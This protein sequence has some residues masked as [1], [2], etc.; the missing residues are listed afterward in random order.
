MRLVSTTP[1]KYFCALLILTLGSVLQAAENWPLKRDIDLSSGFGDYRPDRFHTGVDIRTGG[2]EG[3]PILSPVAGYVYRVKMSYTG[4]GKG[5]YVMGDDGYLYVYGHL[6]L[7]AP[8]IDKPVKTAQLNSKRYYQDLYFPRDSIRIVEG[9]YLGK[10]GKT[11]ANAPHLHFE[12]RSGE[13]YPVNPLTHGFLLSDKV[14]PTFTRI[15]FKL[16]D[17]HSLLENGMRESFFRARKVGDGR[18]KIDSLLYFHRPFGIIAGCFDQMRPGGMKQGIYK[19]SVYVDDNLRYQVIFDSL[20]FDMQSSVNLEYKYDSVVVNDDKWLRVLY[21]KPGNDFDISGSA[22]QSGGII[23]LDWKDKPGRHLGTV[24]AEDCFGN[25][26]ELQFE[27]LWG[28]SE[29]IFT[30]D[31]TVAETP[32]ITKFYFSPVDGY[33]RLGLDSVTV[34]LNR[35]NLWGVSDEVT[36]ELQPDGHLVSVADAYGTKSA[37]LRLGVYVGKKLIPDNLF[38]GLQKFGKE[39]ASVQHEILDDGLLLVLNVK[40]KQGAQAR[41]A[42]FDGDSLLGVVFPRYYTMLQYR[43]FIPPLKK[44]GHITKIG[45]AVTRDTSVALKY[46][47]TLNIYEVGR[48]DDQ[49]INLGDSTTIRFRKD[50]FFAPRFVELKHWTVLGR[51]KYGLNSGYFEITPAAFACKQDFEVD[52][53]LQKHPILSPKTGICWLDEKEN[54]WVW[55]DNTIDSN[56][57][58]VAA[59]AEGGGIFSAH[60][61]IVPPEIRDLNIVNGRTYTNP[62]MT[63]SFALKDTLSGFFDDRNITIKLDSKW[64]IPEFDPVTGICKTWPNEPLSNGS[65]HLGIIVTDRAGNLTEQYLNF[66]MRAKK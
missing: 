11:G 45:Y 29:N 65:H 51:S 2:V 32:K 22:D 60:F 62:T 27:F 8:K 7:F 61:D 57:Y 17:D 35:G 24:V 39:I 28:P 44:Y 23:G 50:G 1:L 16:T 56:S 58:S 41:L 10:T 21:A 18:Y 36:T 38:N 15:G 20:D 33:Q 66:Y 30:L 64:L 4:Y 49:P 63:I 53:K 3:A 12:K 52:M 14:K 46:A 47:D 54:K 26:S 43:A 48:K 13:N 59:P 9:E 42:L 40:A 19:L 5:L 34:F 31:S 25:S 55:L 6:S 37:V